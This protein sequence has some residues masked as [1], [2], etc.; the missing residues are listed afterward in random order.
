MTVLTVM[1]SDYE[2]EPGY[3]DEVDDG[4]WNEIS[5]HLFDE[6]RAEIDAVVT[7]SL[8]QLI[9]KTKAK[10]ARMH[11]ICVNLCKQHSQSIR[12]KRPRERSNVGH[13]VQKEATALAQTAIAE[14]PDSEASAEE[15]GNRL[16]LTIERA[17]EAGLSEFLN[18]CGCGEINGVNDA[19]ALN[20]PQPWNALH[21]AVWGGRADIVRTLLDRSDFAG[22]NALQ[23][24][25]G[26]VKHLS[27]L[28][29][30][31]IM[32]HPQCVKLLLG[33]D[34]YEN[35]NSGDTAGNTP[36]HYAM[37]SVLDGLDYQAQVWH[38]DVDVVQALIEDDRIDVNKRNA[39]GASPLHLA[40]AQRNVQAIRLMLANTR[41]DVNVKT[42]GGQTA[43]HC[44]RTGESVELMLQCSCFEGINEC[45][46]KGWTALH[47]FASAGNIE[48]AQALLAS[49]S[50]TGV[51]AR[52]K[53]GKTALH[54]VASRSQN[55][56]VA[57]LLLLSTKFTLAQAVDHQNRTALQV[58]T[59]N[60]STFQLMK[61]M[62]VQV[63]EAS[64]AAASQSAELGYPASE[65]ESEIN[66]QEQLWIV[67]GGEEYGGII[68]RG[69]LNR[70]SER[71][72]ARLSTGALITQ[73]KCVDNRM[74]YS[75]VEGDGPD[76]GWISMV[77]MGKPLLVQAPRQ[78]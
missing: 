77:H 14:L 56:H 59:N 26:S 74:L 3:R 36:L 44:A 23:S 45:D 75:K 60:S 54:I 69:G 1:P 33:S 10:M 58:A 72:K 73:R 15:D 52:D 66:G 29:T 48:A 49:D 25:D 6:L 37:I 5:E 41:I 18:R 2:E 64:N 51:N 40:L 20:N 76:R 65:I 7:E 21:Y 39:S 28:H 71:Y 43:L 22:V 4:Q 19:S 35:L 46:K 38:A 63:A 55:F 34:R 57:R 68:V 24:E 11:K 17:D 8:G 16:A 27:A 31:S 30:A 50:F 62:Q 32:R 13:P 61:S 47:T 42:I 70:L 78:S 67:K 53:S 9:D 12:N